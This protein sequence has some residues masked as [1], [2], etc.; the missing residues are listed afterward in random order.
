MPRGFP[1]AA[2]GRGPSIRSSLTKP[3]G[4]NRTVEGT[5]PGCDRYQHREGGVSMAHRKA[6]LDDN[7]PGRYSVGTECA[8]CGLCL[9]TAPRNFSTNEDEGHSYVS[10]QPASAFEEAQCRVAMEWCPVDAIG[11][12]GARLGPAT[13]REVGSRPAAVQ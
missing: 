4:A 6:I 3:G 8:G 12:D 13:Y 7:A 9:E 5:S 10:R 11:D 1:H 2:E